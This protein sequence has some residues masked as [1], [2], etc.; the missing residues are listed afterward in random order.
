MCRWQRSRRHTSCLEFPVAPALE[1]VV[2]LVLVG[3][4]VTR[5]RRS[6][7]AGRAGEGVPYCGSASAVVFVR[8]RIRPRLSGRWSV[9][10]FDAPQL[11]AT[12][13]TKLRRIAEV[14]SRA[15]I[16]TRTSALAVS[17]Y[18]AISARPANTFAQSAGSRGCVTLISAVSVSTTAWTSSRR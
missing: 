9:G 12:P 1:F 11:L 3:L 4:A 13:S 16:A 7:R 14:Y 2:E 18:T 5:N 15:S 8:A 17:P 6:A 10:A